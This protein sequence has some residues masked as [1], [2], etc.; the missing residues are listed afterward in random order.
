[1]LGRCSKGGLQN[2]LSGGSQLVQENAT[3]IMVAI[4]DGVSNF[5]HAEALLATQT[6][7]GSAASINANFASF[8]NKIDYS[9]PG[10][11]TISAGNVSFTVRADKSSTLVVKGTTT[12]FTADQS[13]YLTIDANSATVHASLAP[14]SIGLSRSLVVDAATGVI[15]VLV[16]G[17]AVLTAP[18]G[19]QISAS[20]QSL[21]VQSTQGD[22]S[23]TYTLTGADVAARFTRTDASMSFDVAFD[24]STGAPQVTAARLLGKTFSGGDFSAWLGGAQSSFNQQ[25]RSSAASAASAA[26]STDRANIANGVTAG[27]TGEP[28][29]LTALSQLFHDNGLSAGYL[30]ARLFNG[31]VSDH[32]ITAVIGPPPGAVTSSVNLALVSAYSPEMAQAQARLLTLTLYTPNSIITAIV[33]GYGEGPNF[34]PW[35]AFPLVLDL[36]GSGIELVSQTASHAHFDARADG[37]R[38]QIGWVGP[39]NGILVLDKNHNGVVD[40]AAEWF[41]E[42]F[43]KDGRATRMACQVCF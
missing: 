27:L 25:Q 2:L 18:A 1:M 15:K 29:T 38:P 10:A 16:G 9:G 21:V 35:W 4:G 7:G 17:G 40:S 32:W 37:S 39:T 33:E 26:L 24:P 14:S 6:L 19:S 36:D 13:A 43:S 5:A 12:Q 23:R 20:G 8:K 28:A 34:Q 11:F 22:W 3:A 42:R 30:S 31:N 41:G